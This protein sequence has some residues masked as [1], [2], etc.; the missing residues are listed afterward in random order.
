MLEARKKEAADLDQ[1]QLMQKH[2]SSHCGDGD[3]R[4]DDE[5]SNKVALSLCLND[6][7]LCRTAFPPATAD[8]LIASRD[9]ATMEICHGVSCKWIAPA[10]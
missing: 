2:A 4:H 5:R 10:L 9:V 1:D 3:A 8:S 7:A 6:K